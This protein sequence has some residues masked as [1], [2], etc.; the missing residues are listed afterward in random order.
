MTIL[1]F[2]QILAEIFDEK[3]PTLKISWLFSNKENF[4]FLFPALGLLEQGGIAQNRLIKKTNSFLYFIDIYTYLQ[5]NQMLAEAKP[6][7]TP[8][9]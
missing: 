8:L 7:E 6:I 5:A 3:K 2:G 4:L 1:N 9:K